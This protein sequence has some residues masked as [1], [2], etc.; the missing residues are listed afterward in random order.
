MCFFLKIAKFITFPKE[1][2]RK[3]EFK[4]IQLKTRQKKEYLLNNS[5]SK[6]VIDVVKEIGMIFLSKD[7]LNKVK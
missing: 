2:M 6:L 4:N 7:F 1:K 3:T 5:S